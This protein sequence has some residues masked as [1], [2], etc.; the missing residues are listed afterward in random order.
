MK[1]ICR[2]SPIIVGVKQ[3]SIVGLSFYP[4]L[5][6]DLRI[7]KYFIKLVEEVSTIS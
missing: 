1:V 2:L 5:T 3:G 4:E 7:H 6:G